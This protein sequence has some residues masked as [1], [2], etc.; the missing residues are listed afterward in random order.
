MT[1]HPSISKP[2]SAAYEAALLAWSR[3]LEETWTPA[4]IENADLIMQTMLAHDGG[5]EEE[6]LRQALSNP[7]YVVT[8]ELDMDVSGPV[9]TI[10][11]GLMFWRWGPVGCPP[12]IRD[13]SDA[14]FIAAVAVVIELR[15]WN[16]DDSAATFLAGDESRLQLLRCAWGL[17]RD[18]Q[19]ASL[20][21]VQAAWRSV[22]HFKRDLFRREGKTLVLLDATWV[23]TVCLS[24]LIRCAAAGQRTWVRFW[25]ACL[26][27]H[28]RCGMVAYDPQWRQELRDIRKAWG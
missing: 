24:R 2:T 14:T 15:R 11:E 21:A 8:A 27:C 18:V 7:Q 26:Y 5:P 1:D 3:V 10:E 23:E 20:T 22:W 6:I 19:P 4:I 25:A 12:A 17:T 16:C 28:Y 13:R 9:G